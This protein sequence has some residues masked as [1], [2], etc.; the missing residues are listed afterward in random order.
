MT[1]LPHG[2]RT[3]EVTHA[4]REEL[5]TVDT[6]AFPGPLSD[7]QLLALPSPLS[8]DRTRGVEADDGELVAV[9]A[10][11]PFAG[12]PVP[13]ARTAVSGLTWVGVHPGHRRRGL[14]RAMIDEHV[15]RSLARGEALSALF[16]AEAPIYGRFGYGLA[17]NDLRLTVPRGAA[18]RDVPGAED[19]RVRLERLGPEHDEVLHRV[20]ASVDRPG[21]ATRETP[22][23]RA[24]FMSDPEHGR[25]GAESLR[26]ALAEHGGE[27][28]GYAIFR[29]RSHWDVPGPRGVVRVREVVAPG[30][31]VARALW[32]VLLDLDLMAKVETWLMPVDDPLL[33]LLVDPRA[34]EPRVADN[35]WLRVLDVPRALAARRYSAPVDVV[36]EVADALVPANAGRWRVAGGPDGAEVLPTDAEPDLRLDV[37]SLGSA[38]LGGV[39]LAALAGAGLVTEV[40]PGALAAAS[41]AF[42]WPVAPVCSWVF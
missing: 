1:T 13:G 14:L 37:R 11:Y 41:T 42:G 21:W 12:F 23:L 16:A 20:H 35:V 40:R 15:R 17:A 31:A 34:A 30:P 29:R 25:D 6:W 3:V 7:E 22:E 2:Y 36:L 8:W 9:H 24:A 39:T 28:R 18:L 33:H 10:S 4:R 38:Y 5:L 32:G 27:V 19:V 26:I